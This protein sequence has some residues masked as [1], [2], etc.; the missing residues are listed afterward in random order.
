MATPHDLARGQFVPTTDGS[1]LV[2]IPLSTSGKH[3]DGGARYA[4]IDANDY[5]LVKGYTW[6]AHWNWTNRSYYARTTIRSEGRRHPVRMHRMILG[7]GSDNRTQVDHRN[8]V[9]LDNRRSNMRAA[10]ATENMCNRPLRSDN[11]SGFKGVGSDRRIPGKWRARI[12]LHGVLR[13]L[14][15]FDSPEEAALAYNRAAI[16]LHGEFA[17]VNP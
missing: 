1:G 9:T 5:P 4:L 3:G 2:L 8:H 11:R 12:R 7:L 16:E 15:V 6:Q 13:S 10:T 17:W 14:G